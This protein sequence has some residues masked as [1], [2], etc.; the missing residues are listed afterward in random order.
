MSLTVHEVESLRRLV[1]HRPAFLPE[2]KARRALASSHGIGRVQ[3]ARLLYDEH[4]FTAAANLL[5][6]R[7][8]E[9]D[10]PQGEYSRSEAGSGGSEK[11]GAL[12]VGHHLVAA[13]PLNMRWSLGPASV[14]EIIDW[15]RLDL[16]SFDVILECENLLPLCELN[17]YT[18]LRPFIGARRALAVFRGKTGE[19]MGTEAAAAF[20]AHAAKPVLGF[21]D[22]D[23]EGLNMAASEPRLE[24]L[25]LPDPVALEQ[26]VRANSRSHLYL[27]QVAG[28]RNRL[29]ALPAGPVQRAWR[30]LQRL[31]CGLDQEHFPRAAGADASWSVAGAL[32]HRPGGMDAA[33]KTSFM[34]GF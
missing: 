25:C 9:L 32:P 6:T 16:D 34:R 10:G 14:M 33:P 15:R 1:A 27:D 18:W 13:V 7:G 30:L 22:F 28:R 3:G 24:A 26:A 8:F 11:S 23:P 31:Q 12:P 17:S 20:I 4:D 21:Y 5:R 29:N 19:V 2:S